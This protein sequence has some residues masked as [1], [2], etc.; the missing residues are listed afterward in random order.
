MQLLAQS[1]KKNGKIYTYYSL[2][3]SYREGKKSKKKTICYL[4]TLTPLQAHQIRNT[5]KIN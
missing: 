2:A 3:E 4:G 1:R 5:L